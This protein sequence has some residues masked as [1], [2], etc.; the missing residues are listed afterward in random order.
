MRTQNRTRR[1]MSMLQPEGS[2]GNIDIISDMSLFRVTTRRNWWR[3][4]A[5]AD[6]PFL[7]KDNA[8]MGAVADG[9]DVR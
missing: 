9:G 4:G 2:Q 5:G 7:A 8:M 3:D 6:M 1:G